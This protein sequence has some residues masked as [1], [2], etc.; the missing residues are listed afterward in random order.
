M[1]S[2]FHSRDSKIR[3]R[4]VREAREAVSR[5]DASR[6]ANISDVISGGSFSTGSMCRRGVKRSTTSAIFDVRSVLRT[7]YAISKHDRVSRL[8]ARGRELRNQ[9]KETTRF[10]RLHK[11]TG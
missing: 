4:Q 10:P 1:Y 9:G 6:K 8:I 11:L 5:V 3:S 7:S 2:C